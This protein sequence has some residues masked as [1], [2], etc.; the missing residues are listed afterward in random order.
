MEKSFQGQSLEEDLRCC[1]WVSLLPYW[2][3]VCLIYTSHC[4]D[5][6]KI[7]VKR[8]EGFREHFEC[9]SS[10][11]LKRETSASNKNVW[12]GWGKCILKCH[13]ITL[14]H[15]KKVVYLDACIDAKVKEHNDLTYYRSLHWHTWL[16]R[17]R[18]VKPYHVG[19]VG[20]FSTCLVFFMCAVLY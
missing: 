5:F 1:T 16:A 10:N 3:V 17:S 6:W 14:W 12:N 15:N 4:F 19:C 7:F 13:N 18:D 9:C 2:N 11:T 8:V 20:A